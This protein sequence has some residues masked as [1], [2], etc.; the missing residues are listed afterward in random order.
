[1][2]FGYRRAPRSTLDTARRKAT[3]M[4]SNET[5]IS[6]RALISDLPEERKSVEAKVKMLLSVLRNCEAFLRAGSLSAGV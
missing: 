5:P 4:K 6:S 3:I 1:V 2:K